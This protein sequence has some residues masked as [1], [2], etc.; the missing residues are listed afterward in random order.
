HT[1]LP[2]TGRTSVKQISFQFPFYIRPPH[3]AGV[4]FLSETIHE[5]VHSQAVNVRFIT[6]NQRKAA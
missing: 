4:L 6:H 5:V 2:F 3:G 1:I